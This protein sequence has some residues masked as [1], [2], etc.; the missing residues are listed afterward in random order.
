MDGI[1][2]EKEE[3][4]RQAY[5]HLLVDVGQ[6]LPVY[7]PLCRIVHCRLVATGTLQAAQSCSH[8]SNGCCPAP[9]GLV[10]ENRMHSCM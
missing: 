4:Y 9:C 5:C 2:F 7:V 8:E 6:K 3:E 10:A 1:S